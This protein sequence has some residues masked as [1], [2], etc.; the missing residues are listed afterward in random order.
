M[1]EKQTA[2]MLRSLENQ[3]VDESQGA[4]IEQIRY[5]AKKMAGAV[6]IHADSSP[7][8]TLALRKLEESVM[9]A[10]KAIALE[11]DPD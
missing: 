7:E 10:V 4:R 8:R 9:W 5:A 11:E 1:T 2:Y 6:L 3:P